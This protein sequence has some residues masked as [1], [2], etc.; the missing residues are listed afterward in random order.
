VVVKSIL[1]K[2]FSIDDD[3][4]HLQYVNYDSFFFFFSS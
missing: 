3:Q 2:Y 1:K 4:L